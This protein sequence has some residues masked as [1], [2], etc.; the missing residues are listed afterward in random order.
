MSHFEG[1][2]LMFVVLALIIIFACLAISC[3]MDWS[4]YRTEFPNGDPNKGSEGMV[5]IGGNISVQPR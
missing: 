2:L 3:M 4:D 1:N 5:L